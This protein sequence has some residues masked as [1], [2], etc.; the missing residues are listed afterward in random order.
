MTTGAR[1]GE[2]LALRE[3]RFDFETQEVMF[4]KNYLVKQGQRIEKDTKTGEGRR[5]SLDSLTCELFAEHFRR[6]R[7]D[8]A[9]VGVTGPP[10][11]FVFSPDPARSQPWNPDPMTHR[12]DPYATSIG[13]TSSLKELRH[14]SAT[15][16]L[17]HGADLRSRAG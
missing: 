9:V 5:V 16:L 15:Q 10:D 8:L 7:A 13:I 2:M 6:R 11:A 1:R 3:N 4:A 12:Y 14:Y 17:S